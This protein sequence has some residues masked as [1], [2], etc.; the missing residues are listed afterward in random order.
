MSK[1]HDRHIREIRAFESNPKNRLFAEQLFDEVSCK[2]F[3]Y[4]DGMFGAC[5]S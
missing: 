3:I 5:W 2:W 4:S 1:C